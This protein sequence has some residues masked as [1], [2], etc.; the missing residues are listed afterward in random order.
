VDHRERICIASIRKEEIISLRW[1]FVGGSG[2]ARKW[3][4]IICESERRQKV[5]NWKQMKK[6]KMKMKMKMKR[7]TEEEEEVDQSNVK[8]IG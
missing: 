3:K 4:I 8:G 6:K 5:Q 7:E 1:V 2:V